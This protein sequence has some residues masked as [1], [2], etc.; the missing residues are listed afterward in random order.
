MSRN[1]RL[2]QCRSVQHDVDVADALPH[3]ATL[4][5]RSDAIGEG[6][7]LEIETDGVL[8]RSPQHPHER[9]AEVPR[10]AGN[11]SACRSHSGYPA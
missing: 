11:Q 6:R 4:R 10:A 3:E 9:L 2:V 1:V 8:A 5:D 7:V